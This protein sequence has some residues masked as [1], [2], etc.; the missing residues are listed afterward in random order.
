[1]LQVLTHSLNSPLIWGTEKCSRIGPQHITYRFGVHQ[2]WRFWQYC[3]LYMA[4]MYMG[5]FPEDGNF[6]GF[7]SNFFSSRRLLL[8]NQWILTFYFHFVSIKRR[9]LLPTLKTKKKEMAPLAERRSG[10]APQHRCRSHWSGPPSAL[11]PCPRILPRVL[12]GRT[13]KAQK[14]PVKLKAQKI[15]KSAKGRL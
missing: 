3:I 7:M 8:Q 2:F 5:Q 9:F 11:S 4:V 14:T 15:K 6:G 12:Q 10:V 1:M 13:Q